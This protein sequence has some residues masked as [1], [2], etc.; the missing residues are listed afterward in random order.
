MLTERAGSKWRSTICMAAV[1]LVLL[2][3]GRVRAD[4]SDAAQSAAT[5]ELARAFLKQLFVDQDSFGAY[6]R[7]AAPDFVQHNPEMANG[8]AGRE[9]FFT[10]RARQAG[11]HGGKMVNVYNLVLVDRDLF[12]IHHHAFTGPQEPGRVFVD[13][14]RVAQGR[15]VEHWDVIQPYP[16]LMMHANGMACGR[17]ESFED[18]LKV[19]SSPAATTCAAPDPHASREASIKV[20]DDYTAAVRAGDIR[21]AV[22]RWFTPDYRQHSPNIADGAE[23]AIRY[24]EG[25]YGKAVRQTPRAVSRTRIVAEGDY[26]LMHRQVVYPG[27]ARVSTNVDIFRVRDA[28]VSEH[29]DVKQL[30]PETSANANGMW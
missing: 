21:A 16:S 23:G 25:E 28:R 30:V 29:W 20:I 7:F 19:D 1:F 4:S 5:R 26:V 18:A 17:G 13:I 10:N 12:A 2:G 3:S 27:S 11:G 24:L 15:I 6:R 22:T 8:I 9:A 14:W